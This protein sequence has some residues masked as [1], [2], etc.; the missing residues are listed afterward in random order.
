MKYINFSEKL[1]NKHK[2]VE[3]IF[4]TCKKG[5]VVCKYVYKSKN[6]DWWCI[7]SEDLPNRYICLKDDTCVK[8]FATKYG[9]MDNNGCVN[10]K[11][12]RFGV[13]PIGTN[14]SV[15]IDQ[16]ILKSL[17]KIHVSG[18]PQRAHNSGLCWYSAM[19]F[20]AFFCKQMRDL[21]KRKSNDLKFNELIE[22]CLSNPKDAETLR[23]HLYYKYNIGD[24]PK[25][26][27]EKDGQNGCSELIVLCAKL[28]IKMFRLFAPDLTALKQS[29]FDK[30]KNELKIEEPHDNSEPS[31]LIVRCFR[32][33][34][35][36][37]LRIKRNNIK[38]KLVSVMIGS[39]HCGHQI[40]AST[41]DLKVCR[42][43]CA[44]SDA[45]KYGLGPVY[46][47]VSRLKSENIEDFIE[48][49]WNVWSKMI[50][51]TLFS[52]DS[53]CDFSPWNRSTCDLESKMKS[54]S[55]TN[56]NAGVVNSDFIYISED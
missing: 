42:W 51:I 55:C 27:P 9:Y 41:C 13:L 7:L 46:W 43:A 26:D 47:K 44:D 49:W 30:K 21:L 35:R 40:G 31:L 54:K 45:C 25:Q 11:S 23:H 36:P 32:T 4:D 34:W 48:R 18:I 38:Y 5:S 52:S 6:G 14:L 20:A 2:I 1:P 53:F 37:L 50:P 8:K 29:V 28:N 24:N 17:D 16:N 33:R 3:I 22:T 39:E 15:S 19:C 12:G 56:F 10:Y